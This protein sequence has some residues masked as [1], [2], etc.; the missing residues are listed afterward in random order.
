MSRGLGLRAKKGLTVRRGGAAAR[1]LARLSEMNQALNTI[2]VS[3]SAGAAVSG[4]TWSV[5]M[6]GTPVFGLVNDAGG[7]FLINGSTGAITYSG[8]P[9][10]SVGTYNLLVGIV[11][12]G[13]W[14]LEEGSFW[15]NEDG[16][17][18]SLA[19]ATQY[20]EAAVVV[21]VLAD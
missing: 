13:F 21:T 1:R 10:L 4:I 7:R 17:I 3:A 15:L 12:S 8:S 5:A 18:R 16:S 9:A 19:D 2:S 14:G 11:D 6:S 20:T